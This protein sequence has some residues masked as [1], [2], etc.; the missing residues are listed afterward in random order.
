[1]ATHGR[2]YR[3]LLYESC[4]VDGPWKQRNRRYGGLYTCGLVLINDRRGVL[5]IAPGGLNRMHKRIFPCQSLPLCQGPPFEGGAQESD[6]PLIEL[7][8]RLEE[9]HDPRF[10][11][12][13]A[14]RLGSLTT[15]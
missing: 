7:R 6:D 2:K 13:E 11:L 1:M 15:N 12:I 14:A 4:F 5:L 3:P 9:K 10:R 8:R